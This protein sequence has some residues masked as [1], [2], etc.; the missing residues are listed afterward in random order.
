MPFPDMWP[1]R[2]QDPSRIIGS[3]FIQFPPQRPFERPLTVQPATLAKVQTP[4]LRPLFVAASPGSKG[5]GDSYAV[6]H[7]S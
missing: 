7:V 2:I 6:S 5:S 4:V 1:S 3:G